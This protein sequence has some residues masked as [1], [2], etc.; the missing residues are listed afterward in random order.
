MAKIEAVC[1]TVYKNKILDHMGSMG[2]RYRNQTHFLVEAIENQIKAD[3]SYKSLKSSK[4]MI[5]NG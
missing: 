1:T 2:G 3:N 4:S 5:K